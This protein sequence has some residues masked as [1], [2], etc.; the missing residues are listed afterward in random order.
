MS[1][2]EFED[3]LSKHMRK[4]FDE[5]ARSEKLRLSNA[6]YAQ[7]GANFG[8]AFAMESKEVAGLYEA[9]TSIASEHKKRHDQEEY[10]LHLDHERC[11]TVLATDT[12]I[13]RQALKAFDD[14]RGE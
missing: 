10:W 9:L 5:H 3:A 4:W 1:R 2:K 6:D 14:A 13:A 7:E 11:A 12:K 8:Y